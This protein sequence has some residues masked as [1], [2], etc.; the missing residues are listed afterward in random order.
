M[1]SVLIGAA[2]SAVLSFCASAAQ[3]QPA[4]DLS[5]EAEAA[6][7]NGERVRVIVE[8]DAALDAQAA[9]AGPDSAQA[10]M[11]ALAALQD[12][13]MRDTFGLGVDEARSASAALDATDAVSA[14]Q[15]LPGPYLSH[16]YR[17]A[18]AMALTL[19]GAQ[20][21]ALSGHEGV[22]RIYKDGLNSTV[23][24]ESLVQIG[25]DVLHGVGFD[26][27]GTVVAV[28]DSGVDHS[29]AMF[30][31]AIV[32]S[33]CFSS[34]DP[35]AGSISRC[36]SGE[37]VEIGPWAAHTG[38]GTW[39]PDDHGTHVAGTVMGRPVTA[40][41]DGQDRVLRGVAPAATLMAVN[42]F[43]DAGS[44]NGP[45][46]YD[47]D[48]IAGLEW[49]FDNRVITF[50]GGD[51][52]PV[53]AANM[54]LGG[55]ASYDY[56]NEAPHT[57]IISLLRE[58]GVAS[59]IAT[60]N[61]G[62]TD[63]VSR[64]G[65]IEPAISVGAV[66][67]DDVIA[68]FSNSGFAVDML[69]PG[70]DIR[71]A[72]IQGD[73]DGPSV[74]AFSGTSMA[75]PHV[76]GSIALLRQAFPNASVETIERALES[77]GTLIPDT[78]VPPSGLPPQA[79]G[80][81]DA[82]ESIAFARPRIHLPFALSALNELSSIEGPLEIWPWAPYRTSVDLRNPATP[83]VG[84][85]GIRND[86]PDTVLLRIAVEDGAPFRVRVP[87]DT[88]WET[89]IE[90]PFPPA[91]E[92]H[93]E[94]AVLARQVVEGRSDFDLEISAFE[95][96]VGPAPATGMKGVA[97]AP[98]GLNGL[99]QS[100]TTSLTVLGYLGAQPG[101]RPFNDNFADA[102]PISGPSVILNGAG[103]TFGATH[104]TGEP[105][106]GPIGGSSSVWYRYTS[107]VDRPVQ[108]RVDGR[109]GRTAIAVYTG[110]AVD[111]LTLVDQE[112]IQGL[113]FAAADFIAQA[114]VP[115]MIAVD[116]LPSA[117]GGGI[118]A[119]A[120]FNFG[121]VQVAGP[122]D[123]FNSAQPMPGASGSIWM[124]TF[125]A[126][127]QRSDP[128]SVIGSGDS[129]WAVMNGR[130]GDQVDILFANASELGVFQLYKGTNPG[131]LQLLDTIIVGN[132]GEL[133]QHTFDGL[134]LYIMAQPLGSIGSGDAAVTQ[135]RWRRGG[136]VTGANI[137]SGVLPQMRPVAPGETVTGFVVLAAAETSPDFGR[138]C[139]VQYS[140]FPGDI[141][142]LPDQPQSVRPGEPAVL[143][144]L[145][146]PAALPNRDTEGFFGDYI[147]PLQPDCLNNQL[148]EPNQLSTV[149]LE[150]V[151]PGSPDMTSTTNPRQP[152]GVATGPADGNIAIDVTAQNAGGGAD[153]LYALPFITNSALPGDLRSS[154]DE[155]LSPLVFGDAPFWPHPV[156]L[157][158][159]E[160]EANGG[161]IGRQGPFA[162]LR[163][164]APGATPSFRIL[165]KGE[166]VP[167]PL[168]PI[169]NRVGV[170]FMA[171]ELPAD[172][173]DFDPSAMLFV[174]M[175]SASI[176]M[177]APR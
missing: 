14:E 45:N 26:G 10:Q 54:S 9:L 91:E 157:L 99:I 61:N 148:T 56:C 64:P 39:R 113:D 167:I 50:Q 88:E 46:A 27:E 146:T 134:P 1:K 85:Y 98:D 63:L 109:P 4:V 119:D 172:H 47:S 24:D 86:G 106:H 169:T 22:V 68:P 101:D 155:A 130:S 81:G 161:C 177:T 140:D 153:F 65:C 175:S 33:A 48:I 57:P 84:N 17:Y 16:A 60:G 49:V 131:D 138:R 127:A 112:A 143:A 121:V 82:P 96:G 15:A 18:P 74:R 23:M 128:S 133:F 35:F 53:V 120:P 43:M 8:L 158:I 156:E 136:G 118:G 105:D 29:H 76:A 89:V 166:G 123:R 125:G 71:S 176:E 110:A 69:A 164:L 108:A 5:P 173:P 149:M 6:L 72:V 102:A 36:P 38:K 93:L 11:A 97:D 114:G 59:V 52:D 83:P 117:S 165:V 135:V 78:R 111:Q 51:T 32:A 75:T 12:R 159:C 41:I 144:F 80:G 3:A 92:I 90:G 94:V 62:Y 150:L 154:V 79:V 160:S 151:P 142:F 122:A 55:G 66:D 37:S 132:G 67:R 139:V 2:A 129:A 152:N 21:E 100:R 40:Y 170:V 20:I 87:G 124:S 168:D 137:L 163:Q 25:A 174:G 70:V 7:A 115:Y 116:H 34:N 126:T 145:A 73:G 107:D 141:T 104:E 171:S 147:V 13:V 162:L 44:P 31:G 77:T 58:A 28:L 95:P 19:T 103:S 42:V 30:D